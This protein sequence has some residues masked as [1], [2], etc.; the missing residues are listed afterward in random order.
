[1]HKN[2]SHMQ[3]KGSGLLITLPEVTSMLFLF[4]S[5][6]ILSNKQVRRVKIIISSVDNNPD[7]P[8]L[9]ELTAVRL[10]L[11]SSSWN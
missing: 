10:T 1:M 8:N 4:S 7:S 3:I 11:P 5:I 9:F 2:V 6:N